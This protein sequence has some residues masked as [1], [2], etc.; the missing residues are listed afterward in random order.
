[1][2]K[3]NTSSYVY[4]GLKALRRAAIRAA[5]EAQRHNQ[6][7]PVMKNGRLVYVSP[8]IIIQKNTEALRELKPNRLQKE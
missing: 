1:M 5:R 6:K 8:E 4:L 7:I 3:V 2:D